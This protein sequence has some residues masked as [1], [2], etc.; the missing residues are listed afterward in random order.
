[1]E[2][3]KLH[4][5]GMKTVNIVQYPGRGCATRPSDAL[6][7]KLTKGTATDWVTRGHLNPLL[8]TFF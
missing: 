5:S 4:A 8:F 3:G 6:V 7:G 2:V 1:M